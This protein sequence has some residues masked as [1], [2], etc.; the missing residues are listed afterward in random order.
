M[1][2]SLRFRLGYLKWRRCTLSCCTL[3]VEQIFIL[4]LVGFSNDGE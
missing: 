2:L 1:Q 4:A 3:V